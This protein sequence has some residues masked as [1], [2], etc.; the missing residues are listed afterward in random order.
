MMASELY[1]ET[2]RG[3]TGGANPNTITIPSGQ[4]LDAS[5]GDFLPASGQIIQH[6]TATTTSEVSLSA[7]SWTALVTTTIVPKVSNSVLLFQ[8]EAVRLTQGDGAA[9]ARVRFQDG[10]NI[11]VTYRLYNNHTGTRVYWN[12]SF[13]GSINGT[14]TAGD[15]L[16]VGVY[17]T[18]QSGSTSLVFGDSGSTS[19]LRVWEMMP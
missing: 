19:R 14:H 10:T 18:R 1:V 12:P 5:A 13:V 3:V 11:S 9:E 16:T 7:D 4:T 8:C 15:T 2:L 6:V 17:C